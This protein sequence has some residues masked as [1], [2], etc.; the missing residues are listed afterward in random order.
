MVL[1]RGEDGEGTIV[2]PGWL[3]GVFLFCLGIALF[4]FRVGIEVFQIRTELRSLRYD[5][6]S[7]QSRLDI[8]A[9]YSCHDIDID[10][11]RDHQTTALTR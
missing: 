5:V 8:T 6:C 3:I 11:P 1:R 10:K 9:T 7:I 2:V 4:G